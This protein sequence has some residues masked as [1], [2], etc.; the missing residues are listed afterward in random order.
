MALETRNVCARAWTWF[1]AAVVF[2]AEVLESFLGFKEED[3]L[4]EK[5]IKTA[6][7]AVRRA[8]YLGIDY[9]L[10]LLSLLIGVTMK[11]LG[12]SLLGMFIALWIF[13]FVVAG[14]F[15]V[16]YEVT[17]KD[18]SLGEDFRRATDTING[19]SRVAGLLTT[20]GV[21]FIGIVWTGPEK[22]ITFFRKEIGTTGRL[23][24]VLTTLT[25]IQAF[26]YAA[27]YNFAYDLAVRWLP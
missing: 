5:G 8:I 27:L 1:V 14:F 21:I 7:F 9:G 23:V 26:L 24:T 3:G 22:V 2:I 11:A 12:F 15:V 10:I 6:D 18:L 20:L 16:I 17:G 13:D 25:A 4:R 19:R